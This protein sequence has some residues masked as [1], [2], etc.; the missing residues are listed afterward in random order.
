[1]SRS[2]GRLRRRRSRVAA[3]RAS[4]GSR[5]TRRAPRPPRSGPARFLS[6]APPARLAAVARALRRRGLEVE[7]VDDAAT[8]RAAVLR[9]LGP[10]DRVLEATSET[11][12]EIGLVGDGAPPAPYRRLRPELDRLARRGLRD[13]KRRRGASP[14]VIVGSVHAITEQGEVL[15]ASGSGSQL[16]P[17]GYGAGRVIWVVG[18]QKIVRD[19]PE[20][21]RRI[22]EFAVR[23]EDARVRQLGGGGSVVN[24][25]L[26]VF[27]EHQ[28]HRVTIIL[29]RSRLGV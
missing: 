13:E 3:E 27:G 4:P 29:S 24:K 12:K 16:G 9:R 11:L 5:D 23:R 7:L 17:Y 15:I 10:S 14:D 6:A 22:R 20:G 21:L 26:V 2:S 25:L 18:A 28:A 8:A 1:M 19:L